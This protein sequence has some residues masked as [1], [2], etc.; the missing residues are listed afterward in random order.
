MGE[1]AV[2]RKKKKKKNLYIYDLDQPKRWHMQRRERERTSSLVASVASWFDTTTTTTITG[3]TTRRHHHY[4]R[5]W[6]PPGAIHLPCLSP[7]SSSKKPSSPLPARPLP[8]I[9]R[10][11]HHLRLCDPPF[12]PSLSDIRDPHWPFI[13]F[14]SG[15]RRRDLWQATFCGVRE[16]NCDCGM[17]PCVREVD[18]NG[19]GNG[20]EQ[21]LVDAVWRI[22]SRMGKSLGG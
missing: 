14:P 3:R 8:I 5:P 12:A 7:S 2:S 16:A 19:G 6:R 22:C 20:L 4:H 17:I 13:V 10:D 15:R 11:F 9:P 21:L 18:G 1:K